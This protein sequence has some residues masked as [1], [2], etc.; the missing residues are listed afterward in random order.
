MSLDAAL[1]RLWYGPRW[2]SLPLWPLGALFRGAVALRSDQSIVAWGIV[3]DG[4]CAV[5]SP[6]ADFVMVAAGGSHSV[7][8]K[9]DGSIVA[10]GANTNGQCNPPSPNAG[11]VAVGAGASHSLS[12][13]GWIPGDLDWDGDVDLADLAQLLGNYGMTAGATYDDGDLDGDGDVD[14]ADLAGLLA[15]YGEGT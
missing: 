11:F 15:H 8:L 9:A 10:W 3:T 1:Q 13:L 14:L 6:N 5:P 12:L 7:G 4:Q 2:K